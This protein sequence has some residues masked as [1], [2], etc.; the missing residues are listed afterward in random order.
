M[1]A[2]RRPSG[3]HRASLA[4][5]SSLGKTRGVPPAA[6]TTNVFPARRLAGRSVVRTAYNTDRPSGDTCGSDTAR[7]AAKSSNVIGRFCCAPN[8]CTA[9]AASTNGNANRIEQII[10]R[11]VEIDSLLT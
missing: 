7:T 10:G 1:Y 6:A 3:D 2:T 5:T 4:V 8:D 9:A 11:D